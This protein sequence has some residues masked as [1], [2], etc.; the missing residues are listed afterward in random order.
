VDSI[1]EMKVGIDSKADQVK[2]LLFLLQTHLEEYKDE[3]DRSYELYKIGEKTNL[4]KKLENVIKNPLSNIHDLSSNID[5][6]AKQIID[7]IVKS[8]F[9]YNCKIIQT[10]YKTKTS[11]NDLHYSIVLKK[12]D[13][14][15][16][17]RIFDFFDKFY[18][19]DISDKYPVYFQFVP[20]EL[21]G[22]M[23]LNEEIELESK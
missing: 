18:I 5:L 12:D 2:Q 15:N 14:D 21:I 7:G 6:Q 10:A 22:K 20:P 16:R 9:K 13:I 23:H 1:Q 17:N 3:V 8:F 4:S 11:S 19:L